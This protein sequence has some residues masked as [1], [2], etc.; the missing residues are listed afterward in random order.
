MKFSI[1]I[2]HFKTGK[3]TA[4]CIHEVNKMKGKHEVEF[5]VV[6]NSQGAGLAEVK[7]EA[8][9]WGNVELISYPSEL[10]QSHGIAFDYIL[11]NYEVSDYFITLETDSFPTN[12]KWLDYYEHS[13]E[14][15]YDICGSLLKLS[16]GEYI[17]PAGAMYKR[18]NWLKARDFVKELNNLYEYYPN[19]L[20]RNGDFP[21]HIMKRRD[22][23]IH[24]DPEKLHHSY[25][26]NTPAHQLNSYIPIAT[27]VFHNGMG[28][29]QEDYYT[30]G[31][32]T[33]EDG[34]EDLKMPTDDL[35]YRMGYEPGQ[36]FSYWHYATNKKIQLIPTSI[37]WMP[38]WEGRQQEGTLTE[39]GV[40]HL[41]GVSAY[42]LSDAVEVQD[43]TARKLQVMNELYDTIHD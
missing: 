6:D 37:E 15:G 10:M 27:S 2:P 8:D 11:N 24:F 20:Y 17:H 30:Y 9:K 13:I 4:Y 33:P 1:L 26:N 38:G 21:Y 43:I 34:I 25:K 18:E 22:K 7:R 16:G 35:I 14:Q 23:T 29:L 5:F 31:Q 28:A 12:D 19:M 41:W 39:N 42:G 3:M 40:R 36:F 32:R